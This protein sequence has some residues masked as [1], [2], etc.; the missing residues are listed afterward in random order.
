[1]LALWKTWAGARVTESVWLRYGLAVACVAL[2]HLLQLAIWPFIPPSPNLLFYPA[3]FLAARVGGSGPG[4]LATA[5]STFA[6]AYGFLPPEGLLAIADPS[7]TLD[8]AIFFGVGIGISAALG[9]L[10]SALRRQTEDARHARAAKTSSDATWSMVAHD[11]RQ[12]LSVITMGS[13]ELGRR[14]S[15]PPDMER[16][17]RLIQRSTDRARDL[18]DHALDAMRAAEGKLVVF[19]AT[20]DAGELCA[21]A[22]DGVALLAAGQ[23]VTMESDVATRRAIRCDQPRVEQVLTNLLGNALKFTPRGGTVSLYADEVAEGLLI[24]VKDTGRGIPKDQLEAIFTKFWSGGDN[25]TGG[26]G[27]GLGLWI[28]CAILD[29]HGARLTV[30]SRVGEGTT[31]AFTLPFAAERVERVEE[32]RDASAPSQSRVSSRA[33]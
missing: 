1:M 32:A 13:T 9:Q 27:S 11:L 16:M 7:D 14:A 23:G 3:V 5:L 21:H 10:R 31:F 6:I 28:A 25:G 33:S 15:T 30:E 8:L 22:L 17:L 4:Y 18:V 26:N 19:P 29:A 20:C 12:P 24:S 2:A